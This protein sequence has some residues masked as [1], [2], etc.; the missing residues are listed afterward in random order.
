MDGLPRVSAAAEDAAARAA[1]TERRASAYARLV[2]READAI[3]AQIQAEWDDGYTIAWSLTP[4]NSLALTRR[5]Y[6]VRPESMCVLPSPIVII[7]DLK[8]AGSTPR[9][10]SCSSGSITIAG[11]P[12]ITGT[13][14]T[15]TPGY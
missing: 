3:V 10:G 6:V 5:G 8:K 13:I 4:E 12:T 1:E 14:T 7:W 15:V 2:Q 11:D 9:K